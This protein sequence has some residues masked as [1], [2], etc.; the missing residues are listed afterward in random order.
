MKL[1]IRPKCF[2]FDKD[3]NN[4]RNTMSNCIAFTAS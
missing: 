1:E 2:P 4:V 3:G